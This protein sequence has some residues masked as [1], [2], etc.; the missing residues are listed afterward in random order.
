MFFNPFFCK[1]TF[2]LLPVFHSNKYK[3]LNKHSCNTSWAL[4]VLLG[5]PLW[6]SSTQWDIFQLS[7]KVDKLSSLNMPSGDSSWWSTFT[8]TWLCQTL[9]FLP[10]WWIWNRILLFSFARS[11]VRLSAY[12]SVN[13]TFSF[14]FFLVNYCLDPLTI[15][16][17]SSCITFYHWFIGILFNLKKKTKK[18]TTTFFGL[19]VCG[20]LVP[21]PGIK[22]WAWQWKLRI[23]TTE[24]TQNS[25]PLILKSNFATSL[26]KWD[27]SFELCK[28]G[29]IL[30]AIFFLL[31]DF[32]SSLFLNLIHNVT[33]GC[34][35]IIFTAINNILFQN[36][37]IFLLMDT[38]LFP[39]F[40]YHE[41]AIN[42]LIHVSWFR[43]ARVSPGHLTK[44]RYAH[45][46][47]SQDVT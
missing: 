41:N 21:R 3:Y 14:L 26:S 36:V 13:Q 35:S 31:L 47:I 7:S 17:F 15:S 18:T 37:T 10:I 44:G 45:E 28:N 9:Q 12:S 25:I 30:H 2:M 4:G 5:L 38:G 1:W 23:L 6:A 34:R 29:I 40:C 39:V 27:L 32:S 8:N 42:I 43:G 33:C 19:T 20:I 16:F 24:L 11:L 46:H 22:L